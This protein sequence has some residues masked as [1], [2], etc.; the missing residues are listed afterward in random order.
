MST[1]CIPARVIKVAPILMPEAPVTYL[2]D[3]GARG[4]RGEREKE[5]KKGGFDGEGMRE[6]VRESHIYILTICI[7]IT[8]IQLSYIHTVPFDPL[9]SM[10]YSNI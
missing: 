6:G 1:Q 8:Y 2:K 5:K 4:G 10:D 3:K 7:R 9:N